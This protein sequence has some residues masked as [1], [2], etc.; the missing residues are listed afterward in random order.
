[1]EINLKK[2]TIGLEAQLATAE[3]SIFQVIK[4]SFLTY[5]LK[6]YMEN[7]ML[8]QLEMPLTKNLI[9]VTPFLQMKDLRPKPRQ[10]FARKIT[11][12]LKM[13]QTLLS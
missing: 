11:E 3:Y 9:R 2:E 8:K 1:M 5:N 6:I 4:V 10:N 7:P 12:E 13:L